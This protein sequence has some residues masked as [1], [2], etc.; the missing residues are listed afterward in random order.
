MNGGP[1]T[2]MKLSG[3]NFHKKYIISMLP[4]ER[5]ISTMPK[6]NLEMTT[7]TMMLMMSLETF[8]RGQINA[9]SAAAAGCYDTKISNP[10]LPVRH[11]TSHLSTGFMGE[12]SGQLN[13][14][15]NSRRLETDPMTRKFGRLWESLMMELL[16]SPGVLVVHHTCGCTLRQVMKRVRTSK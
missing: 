3:Q 12:P 1:A 15:E 7:T 2:K 11:Q 8:F 5:L 16:M 14:S 13:C 9:L 4:H 10:R 6:M